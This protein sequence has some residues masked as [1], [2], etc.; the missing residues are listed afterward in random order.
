MKSLQ[1][2]AEEVAAWGIRKGWELDR[3]RTFGDECALMHSEGQRG[4]GGLPALGVP[5]GGRGL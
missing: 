2:M 5:D 1:Q 4:V 3:H